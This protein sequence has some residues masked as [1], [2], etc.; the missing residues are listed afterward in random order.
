[1]ETDYKERKMKMEGFSGKVIQSHHILKYSLFL[2]DVSVT[3]KNGMDNCSFDSLIKDASDNIYENLKYMLNEYT[4][5]YLGYF[6]PKIMRYS[7]LSPL[8]DHA[9]FWKRVFIQDAILFA[10]NQLRKIIMQ[11]YPITAYQL[12]KYSNFTNFTGGY[13]EFN[14]CHHGMDYLLG[15]GQESPCLELDLESTEYIKECV[16]LSTEDLDL[17]KKDFSNFS[18]KMETLRKNLKKIQIELW[19]RDNPDLSLMEFYQFVVAYHGK[20]GTEG[21]EGREGFSICPVIKAHDNESGNKSGNKSGNSRMVLRNYKKSILR[22]LSNV[23]IGSIDTLLDGTLPKPSHKMALSDNIY[24]RFQIEQVFAPA[25]IDCLYQNIHRNKDKS[26]MGDIPVNRIASFLRL[27]NVF[28]RQYVLQMVMDML[29]PDPEEKFT[30][31]FFLDDF[32][33]PEVML[34]LEPSF[35]SLDDRQ[36]FVLLLDRYEKF[37]DYLSKIA[38]PIFENYFFC[39]LWDALCKSGFCGTTEKVIECFYSQLKDF[40]NSEEHVE[41]IFNVRNFLNE[42]DRDICELMVSPNY[43]DDSDSM[44]R[45]DIELYFKCIRSFSFDQSKSLGFLDMDY[46]KSNLHNRGNSNEKLFIETL[47]GTFITKI[48]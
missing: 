8:L 21:K 13:D 36:K 45:K 41:D 4:Y 43:G 6:N 40:L 33:N 20:M 47:Q 30:E 18:R 42:S 22:L 3:W 35:E 37:I 10:Y 2:P 31:G 7:G 9:D 25:A 17:V 29:I 11:P 32:P 5:N 16:R 44:S 46:I 19:D 23:N 27:P 34:A 39:T 24:L 28:T 12:C 1:M 26:Y 38:F 15:T 14:Q 48:L